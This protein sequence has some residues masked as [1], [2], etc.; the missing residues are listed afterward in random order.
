[1]TPDEWEIAAD[2]RKILANPRDMMAQFSGDQYVTMSNVD[3]GVANTLQQLALAQSDPNICLE[4]R[5]RPAC[6]VISGCDD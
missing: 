4:V 3:V 6:V 5:K 2:L 1:M